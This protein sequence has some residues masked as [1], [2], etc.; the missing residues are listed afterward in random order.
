MSINFFVLPDDGLSPLLSPLTAAR[1]TLDVYIFRLEQGAVEQAISAAGRRGV[2]VRAILD[3][4]TDGNQP[5]YERLTQAGVAARWSPPYFVK[6]HAKCFVADGKDTVITTANFVAAGQGVRDYGVATD[7]LAVANAVSSTFEADWREQEGQPAAS[8]V[9][10]LV[11]SPINSRAQ[12]LNFINQAQHS[13]Y[14]QHEQFD[15]PTVADLLAARAN[16]GVQVRLLLG[17]RVNGTLLARLHSLAPTLLSRT[18]SQP[19][20]H[21]KLLIRDAAAIQIGSLNLTTESLD[22][23]REI[24]LLLHDPAAVQRATATFQADWV[25]ASG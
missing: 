14:V 16:A 25:S 12:T 21:C 17:E 2:L 10:N 22:R 3:R 7:D 6:T 9:A 13:L 23:R 19:R 20:P 24:S 4:A 11:V 8:E 5:A 18:L 15:D 1:Q